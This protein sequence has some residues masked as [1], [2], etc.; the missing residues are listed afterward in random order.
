MKFYIQNVP[1]CT[2]YVKLTKIILKLLIII[3][4]YLH[5][6]KVFC[7]DQVERNF[8]ADEYFNKFGFQTI[9]IKTLG[10]IFVV[11][12]IESSPVGSLNPFYPSIRIDSLDLKM[13][14]GCK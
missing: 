8:E 4:C 5:I 1:I 14:H 7:Q 2:N 10:T 9:Y 6:G 13:I 12:Y 11:D 3:S